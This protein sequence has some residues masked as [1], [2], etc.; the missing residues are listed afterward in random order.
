MRVTLAEHPGSTGLCG[1]RGTSVLFS[2]SK[3]HW[4]QSGRG[5]QG[6]GCEPSPHL[7]PPA[8]RGRAQSAG[9]KVTLDEAVCARAQ[10]VVF[11]SKCGNLP[12]CERECVQACIGVP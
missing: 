6:L 10:V 3:R 12:K 11:P 2:V 9:V 5:K 4:P 1:K 7:I 8:G